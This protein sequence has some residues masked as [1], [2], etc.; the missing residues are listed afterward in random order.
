M[1]KPLC[2]VSSPVDTFSGYGARSRDFI[3]SLIKAKGDEWDIKLLSQRWGST[4][5]GFLN[6]E[7]EEEADLKSRI[8]GTGNQ[9]PIQPDV[10]FQITVPNEFQKVGKHLSI[11]V[12]AGIE[13]TIC[14]PSWIDGCN[15]VDLILVSSEHSK[16]VFE[17]SK[18][19]QKDKTTNQTVSIVELKTPVEVL[20]EGVDLNKYFK[21]TPPKTDLTT[22]LSKIKEDFAF[23]FVG[24]WLQGEFGEDRKNVG[25]MV[26]AFLEVFKGKTNPPALIMKTNSATTSIM[27]RNSMLDKI[28]AIRKTV[29]GRLPNIYLLHGDLEDEDINDIYNHSKVKAMISFTK[30]EGFGRPLLEFSVVEKPVIASGWS[31]HIDFLDKEASIIVGGE[32]KPIHKSAVVPNM[33]IEDSQWF[34][35]N[36]GQVGYALKEVYE[37]YKKYLPLAKKQANISKTKFSLDKMTESLNNILNEKTQPVPKFIPLEL[38]KL[39]KMELP[40]L[41]KV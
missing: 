10:W 21:T 16:T 25:Y 23:L 8:I 15:R 28:E 18:F 32:L 4:P 20:F 35:P 24:H 12:T 37:N 14:D 2:I 9:I 38:P 22:E 33:L 34:A 26:K 39:N 31:G 27:D 13:T 11:G 41:K 19:E 36:D 17:N 3:K 1:N 6:E 5:F 29:N 40:K 7:I 30:G